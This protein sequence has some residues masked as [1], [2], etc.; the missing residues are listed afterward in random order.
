MGS[1]LAEVKSHKQDAKSS[2]CVFR[3]VPVCT[4]STFM[5]VVVEVILEVEGMIVEVVMDVVDVGL[6]GALVVVDVVFV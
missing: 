3:A 5:E 4:P 6:L 2:A 1:Q